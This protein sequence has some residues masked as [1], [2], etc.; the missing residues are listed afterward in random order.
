MLSSLPIRDRT[1]IR[2]A[3]RLVRIRSR[4]CRSVRY[5]RVRL[6]TPGG[7]DNVGLPA[8]DAVSMKQKMWIFRYKVLSLVYY[9]VP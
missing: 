4:S 6:G 1:Q 5:V 8:G 3:C 2:V 9:A 7:Q